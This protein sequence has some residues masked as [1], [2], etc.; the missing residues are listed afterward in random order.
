MKKQ[1]TKPSMEAIKMKNYC[2]I[3]AGSNMDA[4]GMNKELQDDIVDGGW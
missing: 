1:Y 4:N 2:L 3:M